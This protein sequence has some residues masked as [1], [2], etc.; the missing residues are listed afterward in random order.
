M[1]F[2][3][4]VQ[5]ES[6]PSYDLALLSQGYKIQKR[7]VF[8]LVVE[9]SLSRD[10]MPSISYK[11]SEGTAEK[12]QLSKSKRCH[13]GNGHKYKTIWLSFPVAY[14]YKSICYQ[15]SKSEMTL[16][17]SIIRQLVRIPLFLQ[18]PTL[19]GQTGCQYLLRTC[20]C[21]IYFTSFFN[22][23]KILSLYIYKI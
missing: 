2:G 16:A 22:L 18:Q 17:G 8:Y 6:Y 10:K 12:Y 9:L 15:R 23:V 4:D 20:K 21:S 13:H 19:K 14:S 3:L 11:S 5:V 1:F 7:L